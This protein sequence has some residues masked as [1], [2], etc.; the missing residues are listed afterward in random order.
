MKTLTCLAFLLISVLLVSCSTTQSSMYK[1]S[2]DGPGWKV[3]VTKKASLNEEFVCTIN[4][5]AVVTGSFPFIGDNFEK[6][7]TYRGKKVIMN[8][9]RNSTSTTGSDGTVTSKDTYQI[10]VFIDDKLI[11]KFD[12]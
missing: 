6:S 2:D 3:N 11:D 1:P 5:S 10:R 8:G 4:D 9:F 12:F 7:G